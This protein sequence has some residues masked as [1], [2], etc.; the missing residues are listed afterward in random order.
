MSYI[1]TISFNVYKFGRCKLEI[2]HHYGTSYLYLPDMMGN[3]SCHP[4]LCTK[5]RI[6]PKISTSTLHWTGYEITHHQVI[7]IET[8]G[9][10]P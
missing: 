3:A 9:L 6:T 5:P 8:G 4:S 10:K 1:I 7:W 2:E